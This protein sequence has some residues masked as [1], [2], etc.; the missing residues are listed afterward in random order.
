MHTATY[1]TL[2]YSLTFM[3]L[4][5]SILPSYLA[6]TNPL[7]LVSQRPHSHS[8]MSLFSIR[9]DSVEGVALLHFT[10]QALPRPST[11]SCAMGPIVDP[12]DLQLQL[13]LPC[14]PCVGILCIEYLMGVY[15]IQAL[16][17]FF[18]QIYTKV[19][20]HTI[21]WRLSAIVHLSP[22]MCRT[23]PAACHPLD[24]LTP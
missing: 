12:V 17:F 16:P 5:H 15:V 21:T 14:R 20:H 8:Q 2:V 23:R 1:P 22:G 3:P 13:A 24:S 11:S 10:A 4:V 9:V 7:F 18:S 6:L 19:S